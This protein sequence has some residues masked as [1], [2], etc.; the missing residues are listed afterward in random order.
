MFFSLEGVV[1]NLLSFRRRFLN[2]L[3]FFYGRGGHFFFSVWKG[4]PPTYFYL[5]GDGQL[6]IFLLGGVG[7]SMFVIWEGITTFCFFFWERM[8]TYYCLI[9]GGMATYC[10][11]DLEGDGHPSTVLF[12]RGWLPICFSL[13][14]GWPFLCFYWEGVAT[15]VFL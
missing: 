7:R 1:V 6:S 4:W 2:N 12:G 8:A 14:K 5:G 15:I 11:I 3:F 9:W 10:F 13:W